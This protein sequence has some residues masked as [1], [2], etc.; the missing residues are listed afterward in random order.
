MHSSKNYFRQI[1]LEIVLLTKC[2]QLIHTLIIISQYNK[3]TFRNSQIHVFISIFFIN[4]LGSFPHL[5][6]ATP[7]FYPVEALGFLL[8][9]YHI[10]TLLCH[11]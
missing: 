9:L 6:R 10:Q 1:S 3:I 7:L 8:K 2:S 4:R 5:Y 11:P